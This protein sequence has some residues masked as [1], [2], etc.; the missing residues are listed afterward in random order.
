[1][2]I[3]SGLDYGFAYETEIREI[4]DR[5]RR[6]RSVG[7]E[8]LQYVPAPQMRKIKVRELDDDEIMACAVF[9]AERHTNHAI[10]LRRE[11]MKRK[12]GSSY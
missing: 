5:L 8:K 7:S 2:P 9:E 4:V 6:L 10:N 3:N 11:A 12:H 1:M